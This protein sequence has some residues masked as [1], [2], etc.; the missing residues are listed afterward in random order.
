MFDNL[1][2]VPFNGICKVKVYR[3]T[4]FPHAFAHIILGLGIARSHIPGNQVAEARIFFFKVIIPLRFR[5]LVGRPLISGGFRHPNPT[6]VTQ[7][8]AHQCQFGLIGSVDRDTCGM[9]LGVT[10]IGKKRPF[11]ICPEGCADIG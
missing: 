3:K 6:V 10:G 2:A 8:F 4:G 11:F 1:F 9:N 7:A 5:D